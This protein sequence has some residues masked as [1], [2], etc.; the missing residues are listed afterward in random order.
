MR[1]SQLC[2]VSIIAILTKDTLASSS[3]RR[4]REVQRRRQRLKTYTR[5]KL[6]SRRSA[7]TLRDRWIALLESSYDASN[8]V[9]LES[10]REEQSY[11]SAEILADKLLSEWNDDNA[12]EY[13]KLSNR[14]PHTKSAANGAIILPRLWETVA[15]GSTGVLAFFP[16]CVLFV[17]VIPPTILSS[18]WTFMASAFTSIHSS[19]T[20]HLIPTIHTIQSS[21]KDGVIQAQAIVHS[22]PYLL[23][24]VR[25]I[26]LLPL[27]IKVIRKCI[28]LEAWR[29][30]WIRLFKISK[31][32]WRGTLSGSA[33]AYTRLC[34]AWIRR[35]IKA[36][37]QSMVQAHVGSAVGGVFSGITFESLTWST[38]GMSVDVSSSDVIFQDGQVLENVLGSTMNDIP[39]D[40]SLEAVLE[41]TIDASVDMVAPAVVSA[42][43]SAVES[44]EEVLDSTVTDAI[45]ESLSS[46]VEGSVESAVA[47]S[48]SE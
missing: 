45:S 14:V 16:I 27:F 47:E 33:K 4:R 1:P 31:R 2:A 21:I 19:I 42:V 30:I 40:E 46:A 12:D 23:R 9:R 36:M 5:T 32:L 34:P 22:L 13:M 48:V 29:H 44:I 15:M 6:Q 7:E 3:R 11:H 26:K 38:G 8:A 25:R 20:P 37:F 28:I 43:E 10:R 17:E 41:S 35:G 39:I 18:S 24:H